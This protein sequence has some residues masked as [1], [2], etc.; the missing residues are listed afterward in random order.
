M[1]FTS[2]FLNQKHKVQ[3][4]QSHKKVIYFLEIEGNPQ[5]EVVV[6]YHLV[7]QRSIKTVVVTM[8]QSEAKRLCTFINSVPR[9]LSYCITQDFNRFFPPSKNTSYRSY[10]IDPVHSQVLGSN[11]NLKIA[12]KKADIE[13]TKTNLKLV[14]GKKKDF[15]RKKDKFRRDH[16]SLIAQITDLQKS[17]TNLNIK[18]SK[19]RAEEDPTENSNTVAEKLDK[20]KQ[21]KASIMKQQEKKIG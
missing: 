21:E 18:K 4:V 5:E 10:F 1:I 2:K 19:L 11:M 8:T 15:E 14:E 12:E 3:R 6:F 16:D 9:N 17:L 13:K 7:D 20:K